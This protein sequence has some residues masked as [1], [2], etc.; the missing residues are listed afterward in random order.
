M[1][2][3]FK[4]LFVPLFTRVI[5]VIKTDRSP[6]LL[7]MINDIYQEMEKLDESLREIA[8]AGIFHRFAINFVCIVLVLLFR[9]Y[10]FVYNNKDNIK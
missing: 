10:F 5:I 7:F 1:I 9:V 3:N 4:I 8:H 6:Q 2:T